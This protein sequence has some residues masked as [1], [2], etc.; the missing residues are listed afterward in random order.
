MSLP[1]RSARPPLSPSSSRAAK[2]RWLTLVPGLLVLAACGGDAPKG[3]PSD[4]TP[5]TLVASGGAKYLAQEVIVQRPSEISDEDFRAEI[6]ALGGAFTEDAGMLGFYRVELPEGVIADEAISA[7]LSDGLTESAERN[8]II[9]V[10]AVP[11]D[12]LYG[13]LWGMRTIAAEQAWDLTTG[14]DVV[15]AVTDTGIDLSHPDLRDN[16]WKNPGEVAGNGVDDDGNG[17]IDDIY[18]YD[19]T[20]NDA[21][22]RDEHSHG[23]H[24]AGTIGAVGNDGVGVVGVNWRVK[25]QALKM[26]DARGSGTLWGAALA[27]RYAAQNGAR[28]VNASWGCQGCS[29][30]YVS[31]AIAELADAGGLFVAAAG[32]N[33]SNNDTLP[34]YPARDSNRNV[35]AVAALDK[36]DRLASFSNYG[37]GTVH[38]AAPG[39]GITSTLPNNRYGTYSG[40]SMAAP[41]VAGAAALLLSRQ[42]EADPVA[43]IQKLMQSVEP[44]P[45]LATRVKSGG[46]LSLPKLLTIDGE[47]PAPPTEFDATAGDGGD[48]L[49][50]WTT[51]YDDEEQEYLAGFVVEY[52]VTPGDYSE[53]HTLGPRERELHLLDLELDTT[54]YFRIHA[55]DKLGRHSDPSPEVSATPSDRTA[56]PQVIDLAARPADAGALASG[57][58]LEASGEFSENYAA[59]HAADGSPDT[60]WSTPPRAVPQEEFV[61]VALDR[62][63]LLNQV[64][65]WPSKTYPEFFPPDY[66]VEMSLDGATWQSVGGERGAVVLPDPDAGHAPRVITFPAVEAS[67]VRLRVLTGTRHLSGFDYV[68]LAELTAREVGNSGDALSLSFTAPGDNPGYGA[69]AHYDVR[70]GRAPFDAEDFPGRDA[71]EAPTPQVTPSPEHM[72]VQGL[73]ANTTYY[74]AL[75]AT[76]A[77]G[78]TSPM[79][80]LASATTRAVPPAA[81]TDLRVTETSEGRVSLEWTAPFS[82]DGGDAPGSGGQAESYELRYAPYAL[83]AGNFASAPEVTLPAPARAGSIESHEVTGL[84][85]GEHYF[86][87]LRSFDRRLPSSIS[88]VV[89]ARASG[90]PDT[91]P[92]A[93]VTTLSAM[94]SVAVTQVPLSVTNATEGAEQAAGYLCDGVLGSSYAAAPGQSDE[95]VSVTLDAGAVRLLSRVRMHAPLSLGDHPE[96]PRDFR[97][98]GSVDGVAF[99]PLVEVQGLS[100]ISDWHTW[101]LPPTF[102]RYLRLAVSR[103]GPGTCGAQHCDGTRVMVAE[104]EAYARTDAPEVDLHWVGAGDDGF[105]GTA[106]EVEIRAARTPIDDSGWEAAHVLR[107]HTPGAGGDLEWTSL[108]GLEEGRHH[109]ALRTFDEAGN[110]SDVSTNAEILVP[111]VPPGPVTDLAAT[112]TGTDSVELRWTASGDDGARGQAQR[113]DIR[114]DTQPIDDGRWEQAQAVV[115]PPPPGPSGTAE[116]LTITGLSD[117]TTYY[118]A[119]RSYDDAEQVSSISNQALA[120]TLDGTPPAAVTDLQAEVLTLDAD[121]PLPLSLVAAT[122]AHSPAQPAEHLLDGDLDSDFLSEADVRDATRFVHVRLSAPTH[123]SRITL[124]ASHSYPDLFPPAV[125]VAVRTDEDDAF[126]PVLATDAGPNQDGQLHLSVGSLL[127]HEIRVEIP[128]AAAFAGAH[129]VA[130]AELAVYADPARPATVELAW[131]APGDNGRD[132]TASHFDVRTA[133]P[134]L[135]EQAYQEATPLAG[136]PLPGPA[137]TWHR[138]TV[139]QLAFDREHCFALTTL[140]ARQN[141]SVL[142]NAACV[143][144]PDAPP[145]GVADLSAELTGPDQVTLSWTAPAANDGQGEDT[146]HHYEVRRHHRLIDPDNWLD[147]AE[148][149]ADVT[150][151]PPGQAQT[152]VVRGLGHAS[153]HFFAVR[154]IDG[155]GQPAVV[156]NNAVAH[157]P[158]VLPPAAIVDLRVTPVDPAAPRAA[159]LA[160]LADSGSYG[161]TTDG[162]LAFDGHEDTLWLSTGDG[163]TAERFLHAQLP[164]VTRLS[165]LALL[166]SATYP[167]LFPVDM[168]FEVRTD[169][170]GPWRT[171]AREAGMATEPG[172]QRW[173]LGSVEAKEVRLVVERSAAWSGAHY[174]ALAELVVLEDTSVRSA[175]RLKWTAPGDDLSVGRADAYD[176]R[177][178]EAPIDD[179]N[180]AAAD[181]APGAPTPQPAGALE[182]MEVAELPAGSHRCFAIQTRDDEG[183]SSATSNS[184]CIVVPS[185]PPGV[186]TDLST[187]E[188][189]ADRVTLTWTATG[190]EGDEGKADRYEVRMSDARIHADNW[191][192]AIAI[193]GPPAPARAGKSEHFTVTGLSGLSTYYFAIRAVDAG[194]TAGGISNNARVT[195]ADDM[196]PAAV[197]DLEAFTDEDTWGGLTVTFTAPGDNGLS[198]QAARYDVRVATTPIEEGNW[199]TATPVAAPAPAP[200]GSPEAIG[201]TGLSPESDYYVALRTLDAVGNVSALSN[202]ALASTRDE[203]PSSIIDLEATDASGEA[204][205]AA[206][207]SLRWTA[208][209]DDASLG[210]AQAYELRHSP[211]AIDDSNFASATPVTGLPAPGSAGSSETFTVS[212]LEVDTT[213]HFAMIAI[214]ERGNRGRVESDVMVTTPDAVAPARVI[215]LTAETGIGT[216]RIDLSWTAPGDNERVGQADSYE[217]RYSEQAIDEKT[218]S[219]ATPIASIPS[220]RTAGTLESAVVQALSPETEYHFALISRDDAG[221]VSGLSNLASA[222]TRDEAPGRVDDLAVSEVGL[223][224]LTLTWT[225][226]GDDGASGQASGYTLRYATFPLTADNFTSGTAVATSKPKPAGQGEEKVVNGLA[227]NTRYYFA[228][229]AEDDR[230]N[231]S[232][233]SNLLEASTEDNEVPGAI[234]DLSAVTGG[235]QGSIQLAWT[236]PGDDGSSGRAS[237][238]EL[239]THDAPIDGASWNA[240]TVVANVPA[241]KSAGSPESFTV[242][243][244]AGER[245]H[246][247]ALLAFDD[248]DNS[249]DL[250]NSASAD[251]PPVPP[252]RVT[253]LAGVATPGGVELSWTAPGDDGTTGTATRYDLRMATSPITVSNWDVATQLSGVKDPSP[254][255]ATETHAVDG[256]EESTTYYFALVTEDDLSARSSL[257]NVL[258]ITTLDETAPSAPGSL[259][260][261]AADEDGRLLHGGTASASSELGWHWVA[262]HA[263]DGRSHTSWASEASVLHVDQE[264]TVSVSPNSGI[265]RVRLRSDAFHSQLFPRAFDIQVGEGDNWTTVAHEQA[266]EPPTAGAWMQWGFAPAPGTQVRVRATDTHASFGQ[267]YAIIA[268]VEAHEARPRSGEVQLTWLAP[269]DDSDTGRASHYEIYRSESPFGPGSLDTAI[270]VPDA[271]TPAMAG[272][273]ETLS[274][275]GLP[276]ESDFYWA[277][278]AIDEAG[279][280]GALSEVVHGPTQA[281]SPATVADLTAEAMSTDDVEL[282]FTAP[283]DDDMS[284]SATRY[285]LRYA[286][287]P[288]TSH[289][290]ALATA[291]DAPPTPAPAGSAEVLSVG[292]LEPGTTYRFA[293]IAY[294]EQDNASYV[295]NV[296]VA[297]TL[298]GPDTTPPAAIEDLQA[299]LPDAAGLPVDATVHAFESDQPEFGADK[300]A[301]GDHGTAWVSAPTDEDEP[302]FIEL[303]LA[304]VMDKGELAIWPS[305]TLAELFPRAFDV[306]VSPDGLAWTTVHTEVDYHASAGVPLLVPFDAEA[307]SFVALDISGRAGSGPFYA[308]VAELEVTTASES[309]GTVYLGWTAPGDDDHEGQAVAYE[310]AWSPCPFDSATATPVTTDPPAVAGIVER[311]RLEDLPAGELCFGVTS[312]DDEGLQSAPSNVA[313]LTVP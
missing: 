24:V 56:P 103:R 80:N 264:I 191:D 212:G 268:D 204:M 114:Y 28:V 89:S 216:G 281:V 279:N 255:G 99:F 285:D 45:A 124:S 296:A 258:A 148:V 205:G 3:P 222:R 292:G 167:D 111:G 1:T 126:Q 21:D 51:D 5:P 298:P 239:R 27:I 66:E 162:S 64:E 230:A 169:P 179:D 74:F 193:D 280:I 287:W 303:K 135:D 263:L 202:L 10:E 172:W 221:N 305:G 113:Y 289:N 2:R 266:F 252:A 85:P 49:L 199:D 142:S 146:V 299:T 67:F 157:T 59:F 14:G 115:D 198:G 118:F 154:A 313:Q 79:S 240:A 37:V 270:L 238:Y 4:A 30:S 196:P 284:G 249:G 58:V 275:L 223:R 7:F 308:V 185:L 86:F 286:P 92:P 117:R 283:G 232:A 260:A 248:A 184:P 195:T 101:N 177:V 82:E 72:D 214:D 272:T 63:H 6:E 53:E 207:V 54:Y 213:Y 11:S 116:R 133:G 227:A 12:P 33:G 76:D 104:L 288:I 125:S 310:L 47:P 211:T 122:P 108:A 203:A 144:A 121:S 62:A 241:P 174:A 304:R 65:L 15:V 233:L 112:A 278:R 55:F 201:I 206:S 140:D 46:T 147:A 17:Y 156:S 106:S 138:M 90:G 257:S 36:N 210:T 107:S 128:H 52:G 40:T 77:S 109:V 145:S 309:P 245:T 282:T 197:G 34:F 69:A 68:S 9:S 158:D 295:S 150:A 87:A 220:P 224:R 136:P 186:I 119:M 42:D 137:G 93:T 22:P 192:A 29:A 178:A 244:L 152:L 189:L 110:R 311:Y 187:S 290:F 16:L 161:A 57:R 259:A 20:S 163:E 23:T 134:P 105:D 81:I 96:Y 235:A 217:I 155:Q 160:Y 13:L 271:P 234:T 265:D 132:G 228:L 25:M 250:S 277:V 61:T 38:L 129:H 231:V 293:L 262:G 41:H 75:T 123:V 276:G 226:P 190:D 131:T 94:P 218:W 73:A 166:P 229:V 26:L 97:F 294:D 35:V 200:A 84:S 159:D 269:G 208:P 18:G 188:V 243:G 307:T 176:V 209:G 237:R 60:D 182:R 236:A 312:L 274:A 127:A 78:N 44:N 256:L 70:V 173:A 261:T 149:Q 153:E 102:A 180:F 225:A 175:V 181:T 171:V 170:A 139:G 165:D 95:A 120:Q 215:D 194:G 219:S 31:A 143:H 253:D 83:H 254:A 39:V 247:F 164:A 91:T 88:N 246:H 301:D 267:H 242:T 50:S 141:R 130:L 183:L 32:N 19:F 297:T 273:L 151:L 100:A 71:V 168:R 306:K 302:T 300:I 98:E 291:V 8:Y 251:T 43:V 48:V